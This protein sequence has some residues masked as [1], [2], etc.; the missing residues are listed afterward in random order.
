MVTALKTW[1]IQLHKTQVQIMFEV[2]QRFHWLVSTGSQTRTLLEVF[3]SS[4]KPFENDLKK[5]MSKLIG[6]TF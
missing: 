1:R 2:F 4:P 5:Y 6:L 3:Y